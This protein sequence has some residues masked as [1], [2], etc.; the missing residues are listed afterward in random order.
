M[1][2]TQDKFIKMPLS[3]LTTPQEGT[4]VYLDR[5]WCLTD[6]EEVLFFRTYNSPQCNRDKRLT[7]R[8]C[9]IKNDFTVS[10]IFVPVAY[11]PLDWNSF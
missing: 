2:I 7:D 9:E 3:E 5:W 4:I 10:S 11:V 6:K 1:K 8:L